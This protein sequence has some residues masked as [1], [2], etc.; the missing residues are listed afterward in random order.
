MTAKT[1]LNVSQNRRELS[2]WRHCTAC[3]SLHLHEENYQLRL[4]NSKHF[5]FDSTKKHFISVWYF[6]KNH[7]IGSLVV[8]KV[9]KLWE[10]RQ[11]R[12]LAW[13]SEKRLKNS[14][15]SKLAIVLIWNIS[16]S[17]WRQ[18][19]VL[20]KVQNH[21]V[22]SSGHNARS[23]LLDRGTGTIDLWQLLFWHRKF[24]C[25]PTK[26]G[27]C[28]HRSD[29]PAYDSLHNNSFLALRVIHELKRGSGFFRACSRFLF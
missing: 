16:N 8:R 1:I 18:L 10:S 19:I 29:T 17:T 22:R 9:K 5:R 7:E 2:C 4:S 27:R 20:W 26:C 14:S 12:E 23:A 24:S 3:N 28:L 13:T 21:N 11:Y 6:P 15:V 25:D